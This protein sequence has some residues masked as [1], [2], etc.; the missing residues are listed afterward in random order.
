MRR[1]LAA[2]FLIAAFALGQNEAWIQLR[3]GTNFRLAEGDHRLILLPAG[4][5]APNGAPLFVELSKSRLYVRNGGIPDVYNFGGK[6]QPVYFRWV[7]GRFPGRT[8]F[9]AEAMDARNV[10][11]PHPDDWVLV[12]P[13][14]PKNPARTAALKTATGAPSVYAASVDEAFLDGGEGLEY[15]LVDPTDV[16]ELKPLDPANL[17]K[18]LELL[19]VDGALIAAEPMAAKMLDTFHFD[20]TCTTPGLPRAKTLEGWIM[21]PENMAAVG[22]GGPWAIHPDPDGP[23]GPLL[24][25]YGPDLLR[26]WYTSLCPTVPDSMG[27]LKPWYEAETHWWVYAARHWP[28]EDAQLAYKIASDITRR[29]INAHQIRTDAAHGLKNAWRNE[30]CEY[31][32]PNAPHSNRVDSV[33][34][35]H[36]RGTAATVPY[37]AKFWHGKVFAAALARPDDLTF[38]DSANRC[39][40]YWLVNGFPSGRSGEQ[41]IM[42]NSLRNGLL[43]YRYCVMTND[44]RASALLAKATLL[45][46]DE[47]RRANPTN[48]AYAVD[49]VTA[50]LQPGVKPF[51]RNEI[52]QM[53]GLLTA[54]VRWEELGA[55]TRAT[56][57]WIWRCVDWAFTHLP[58]STGT[59]T[60][61]QPMKE[62]P[63]RFIPD[64][65]NWNGPPSVSFNG[66]L[67]ASY[68]VAIAP[69]VEA[70][71][72]GKHTATMAALRRQAYRNPAFVPQHSG[73]ITTDAFNYTSGGKWQKILCMGTWLKN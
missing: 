39:I 59:A 24:G 4:P 40:D 70:K 50:T 46:D 51:D 47:F 15:A 52:E 44:P 30:G 13:N 58:R 73:A 55:G 26:T 29:S 53:E 3:D 14:D 57:D 7:V 16:R 28:S 1:V 67:H 60:D 35:I 17:A 10:A 34:K 21:Y 33:Y 25:Q 18:V 65:G 2:L 68:L 48:G 45:L 38:V 69:D 56:R 6:P 49:W 12:S 36:K 71:F 31:S 37:P 62:W 9:G 43:A 63:Y 19:G 61:G 22:T 64:P 66:G 8:I 5:N 23:N 42:S 27:G 54:L 72:P 41:R 32:G 20:D 11:A